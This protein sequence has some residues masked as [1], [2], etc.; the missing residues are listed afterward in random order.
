MSDIRLEAREWLRSHLTGRYAE[1]IGRGGP[2]D[3]AIWDLNLA[4]EQ[5]LARGG[6]T[7]LGWPKK[8]GG[9][10]LGPVDQVIFHEEYNLANGPGR[11]THI[12]EMMLGPTVV[13]FGTPAQQEKYLP[14]I[15]AAE[16]IWCQGYSEPEA[17]SDLA[18]VRTRAELRDGNWVVTGRKLWTSLAQH[19]DYCFV[20]CRTGSIE[21]RHR[22]LSFL[23]VPM[24]Q[25]GVTVLPVRQMTGTSEFNE[26]IFDEAVAPAD[27]II[28]EIGGGWKIAMAT[29]GYE[30][31]RRLAHFPAMRAEVDAVIATAKRLGRHTDPEIRDRIVRSHSEV[32][33]MGEM[34]R[35]TLVA[36]AAGQPPGAQAS[37]GKLYWSSW[38]QRLLDLESDILGLEAQVIEG[39]P[40]ILTA[41]QQAMLYSRAETIFA[42][43]SEIQRNIIAERVLGLPKDGV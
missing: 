13:E 5:E 7:A 42:G 27:S 40:Y 39:D 6:W 20:L 11:V 43:S 22:G 21:S 33:I 3:E 8:F 37:V 28:G 12:G 18:A 26:V 17:G 38:H 19:A 4:W 2:A 36:I 32:V 1:L 31:S 30:R 35:R 14:G 15:V 10:E 9:R 16:Q 29:L 34:N 23:L 41:S 24:R 25:P